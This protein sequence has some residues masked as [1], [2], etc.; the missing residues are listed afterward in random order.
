MQKCY[1]CDSTDYTRRKGKVRDDPSISILECDDCGLV[2]LSKF[3]DNIE[4]FYENQGMLGENVQNINERMIEC[5]KDD[6]RRFEFLRTEISNKNILDFGCGLGGFLIKSE[7]IASSITGIEIEKNLESHYQNNNICIYPEFGSL[8]KNT[9]FDLITCFHVLEHLP[10]PCSMLLEF[11]KYLDKNGQII[12]EVPSSQDALI[13][14]Y[15][16]KAF[17]H[18]T[19][20]SCHLFLFSQSNLNSIAKKIGLKVNYVKQIQRYPLSN[21]LYWLSKEKPGGHEK[22]P[23]IDSEIINNEYEAILG[24]LD[25]CDTLI[26][27]FSLP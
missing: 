24:R 2:F 17:Q 25:A 16:S 15:D 4:F 14:L 3:I 9:K 22:W 12:I 8:P 26:A 10:D 11:S 5:E 6:Q 23:F 1:L 27:S 19:Y 7:E 13:K 21:H 20:W 18:F